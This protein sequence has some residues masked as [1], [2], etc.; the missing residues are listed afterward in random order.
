MDKSVKHSMACEWINIG[1]FTLGEHADGKIWIKYNEKTSSEGEGGAFD[2]YEL[3]KVIG[4]F[5]AKHF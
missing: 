3:E 4:D 2:E 5:C 1:R